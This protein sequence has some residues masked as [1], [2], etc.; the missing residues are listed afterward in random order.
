MPTL[1]SLFGLRR[2]RRRKKRRGKRKK[3]G[4]AVVRRRLRTVYKTPGKRRRHFSNGSVVPKG[5]RVYRLKS[6]AKKSTKRKRSRTYKTHRRWSTKR[7]RKRRSKS[8]TSKQYSAARARRKRQIGPSLYKSAAYDVVGRQRVY[9]NTKPTLEEVAI[10]EDI[11][12]G[13]VLT[14]PAAAAA[15]A[16]VQAAPAVAA[17]APVVEE[18]PAAEVPPWVLAVPHPP[19]S[20]EGEHGELLDISGQT[21][22]CGSF[23]TRRMLEVWVP[24]GGAC[25]HHADGVMQ[26]H[27]LVRGEV[28]T[29]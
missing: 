8:L 4:Y 28:P 19:A 17:A 9:R 5:K 20:P 2:R 1:L 25:W 26:S 18:A 23:S 16:S 14:G 10:V 13:P 7:R 12:K 6:Q 22:G 29:Q 11:F 24:V 21:R 3:V 27:V 15:A